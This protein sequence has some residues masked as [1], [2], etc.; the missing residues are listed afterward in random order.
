MLET[1]SFERPGCPFSWINCNSSTNQCY[2]LHNDCTPAEKVR[3]WKQ[4]DSSIYDYYNHDVIMVV[5]S[6]F[7]FLFSF[8]SFFSIS[9]PFPSLEIYFPRVQKKNNIE[10]IFENK[11]ITTSKW[12]CWKHN[13]H[14]SQC[15]TNTKRQN[16]RRRH[17]RGRQNER[18]LPP[19]AKLETYFM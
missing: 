9:I 10:T 19:L 14:T 8:R 6:F 16:D 7:S 17:K 13:E 12:W 1:G 15:V 4:L 3:K 18:L 5:R 2:Q 11:H